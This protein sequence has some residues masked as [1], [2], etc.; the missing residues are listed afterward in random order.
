MEYSAEKIAKDLFELAS[1]QRLSILL[2]LSEKKTKVSYM[3][4]KLDATV[5][6]VYRNFERLAKSNLIRKDPDG[7]YSLTVYG[8]TV[9]AQI[10]SLV[11]ASQFKKYLKNHDYADLH[12][13]FI[14]RIGSLGA[15]QHIKGYVK[16]LEKSKEIYQEADEYICNIFS[17]VSY[18]K[19]FIDILA[20]KLKKGIKV[21]SIFSETAIIPKERKKILNKNNFKKFIDEG[22]VERRMSKEVKS[23]VVLNEKEAGVMFPTTD[24]E[25][26]IGEML[27][28]DDPKFHEWCFDFFWDCWS[29]TV[30]FQERKLKT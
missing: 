18:D 6:E 25:T 12:E 5:P 28:S 9:C 15:G 14:Q 10:P 20:A 29:K 27:Y 23:A 30:I 17:E 2:E 1:E 13:K 11:F 24:G 22:L 19:D 7:N 21:N 16:V 26:D 8:K 3:A 4:K